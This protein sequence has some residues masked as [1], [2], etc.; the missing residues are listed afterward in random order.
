MSNQIIDKS[1]AWI[2]NNHSSDTSGWV[3]IVSGIT[4][5]KFGRVVVLMVESVTVATG[6]QV[7]CTVP[8]GILPSLNVQPFMRA[9]STLIQSWITQDGKVN[10][11][12]NTGTTISNLA[13]FAVWIV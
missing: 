5:Q 13:G 12:N 2:G 7:I 10:V 3:T 8:T 11:N 1:L 9:S 4:Y 6:S